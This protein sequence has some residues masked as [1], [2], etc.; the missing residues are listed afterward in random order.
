MFGE[1]GGV[2]RKQTAVE[3]FDKF[4]KEL[5]MKSGRLKEQVALLYQKQ[6]DYWQAVAENN[7]ALAYGHAADVVDWRLGGRMRMI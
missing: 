2:R 7:V 6:Q 3:Q 4:P 1:G 5:E